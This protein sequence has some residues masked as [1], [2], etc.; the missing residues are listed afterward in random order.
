MGG[1]R[2]FLVVLFL[3]IGLVP[4]SAQNT[5]VFVEGEL[6]SDDASYN[7]ANQK[8]TLQISDSLGGGKQK[9]YTNARGGFL[10]TLR[11][12]SGQPGY[13]V[14]SVTNCRNQEVV[15]T[16]FLIPDSTSLDPFQF[17]VCP[18]PDTLTIAGS[19]LHNGNPVQDAMV[20]LMEWQDSARLSDLVV[21]DSSS[22]NARGDYQFRVPDSTF[23]MLKAD[24]KRYQ[25]DS[26]PFIPT[27]FK[28]DSSGNGVITWSRADSLVLNRNHYRNADIH[29]WSAN[30][31][32]QGQGFISGKV[33]KSDTSSSFGNLTPV[34]GEQV[35]IYDND[36]SPLTTR[37]TDSKGFYEFPHLPLG[38]Y[39]VKVEI[40][41]MN[42]ETK[43]VS[44][45]E[46]DL[47][48]SETDFKVLENIVKVRERTTTGLKEKGIS[49]IRLYPNPV[50]DQLT[51]TLNNDINGLVVVR[52][53]SVN[54]QIL[55]RQSFQH[56]AA[57]TRHQLDMSSY[58]RGIYML[59][60]K[61]P[62][63]VETKRILKK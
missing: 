37:V 39:T 40:P 45:T 44:L 18:V 5:V 12:P 34:T 46:D 49:G 35:I 36:D 48:A 23:F 25:T 51:V 59:Q 10:D 16:Q 9:A 53:R 55:H 4:V 57:Q 17:N 41:G 29:V 31:F 24:V 60:I 43:T 62:N 11:V 63:D 21:T 26:F 1:F 50:K 61:T 47:S 27:Y 56:Q 42:A 58:A 7:L 3:M 32:G 52:L 15:D 14:A 54:G 28:Q 22:V 38:T 19:V 13:I 33:F 8:V 30:D 2:F 6:T 20:Y